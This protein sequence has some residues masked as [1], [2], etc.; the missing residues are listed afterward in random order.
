MVSVGVS[1]PKLKS[2]LYYDATTRKYYIDKYAKY[3][4][5]AHEATALRTGTTTLASLAQKYAGQT[6][7]E[8]VAA[9]IPEGQL[10][11]STSRIDIPE[12]GGTQITTTTTQYGD[13]KLTEK[14]N[15]TTSGTHAYS[16]AAG[17]AGTPQYTEKPLT[18]TPVPSGDK[19]IQQVATESLV[20]GGTG[21][22]VGGVLG[23]ASAAPV[24][25][26][27]AIV[28]G[29]AL[30]GKAAFDVGAGV[31]ERV[32][33]DF[34]GGAEFWDYVRNPKAPATSPIQRD[35]IDQK[36]FVEQ[37]IPFL[38]GLVGTV[39]GGYLGAKAISRGYSIEVGETQTT[40][41]IIGKEGDIAYGTHGTATPYEVSWSLGK[42]KPVHVESGV[43]TTTS[44]PFIAG[45]TTAKDI[46]FTATKEGITLSKVDKP[47]SQVYGLGVKDSTL[48]KFSGVTAKETGLAASRT[49][50]GG[51]SQQQIVSGGTKSAIFDLTNLY[52]DIPS[53]T[54][55][56]GRSYSGGSG[57]TRGIVTT[58]GA[59]TIIPTVE[60]SVP[61]IT[62][63]PSIAT[64]TRGSAA[65]KPLVETTEK[66]TPMTFGRVNQKIDQRQRVS[67]RM[68]Y[69]ISTASISG[70][71]TRQRQPQ[72]VFFGSASTTIPLNAEDVKIEPIAAT[73]IRLG[74][75][76]VTVTEPEIV[77]T[78]TPI[79]PTP[80][81]P[82]PPFTPTI[83]L[84][85]PMF[86]VGGKGRGGVG[87][88]KGKRA[89][90]YQKSLIG[91]DIKSPDLR[92][93]KIFTGIE[94]RG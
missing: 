52:G 18:P 70:V 8:Q 1:L 20:A 25:A 81:T 34:M 75:Q 71:T 45:K 64:P 49:T 27:F 43:I 31:G 67:D 73:D 16:I 87:R 68:I 23:A 4:V 80:L 51:V 40:G 82:I 69:P 13:T 28:G 37:G 90:R 86:G 66:I 62:T 14:V 19:T 56:G 5:P 57:S 77:T 74:I 41:A 44:Q 30:A 36:K 63:P 61:K 59:E 76:Q 46:G 10:V 58:T 47:T 83:G 60:A 33:Q 24:I 22:A 94:V 88:T 38:S 72:D 92:K 91:L 32:K 93:Q 84:G 42:G 29:L 89:K 7:K 2:G 11:T 65:S 85:F 78:P 17:S 54:K 12:G 50:Y 3:E 26:P 35:P 39:A 6:I 55:Y 48:V 9:S 79:T 53:I 15:K 21:L